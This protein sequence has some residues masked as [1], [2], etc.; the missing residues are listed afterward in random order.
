V[1]HGRRD[2]HAGA[3][4]PEPS[5]PAVPH[6]EGGGDGEARGLDSRPPDGVARP[7]ARPRPRPRDG[8][9]GRLGGA[10]V[11][12][13]SSLPAPLL[14]LPAP[15][16]DD[17]G[18]GPRRRFGFG[19][20]PEPVPAV[21]PPSQGGWTTPSVIVRR[22]DGSVV[23]AP[24]RTALAHP[25]RTPWPSRPAG[26]P[27][28][29]AV[30]P[31]GASRRRGP[32][33][34]RARPAAG[35]VAQVTATARGS[36]SRAP[37]PPAGAATPDG[38]ADDPRSPAEGTMPVTGRSP[39][40][41]EP[42]PPVPGSAEPAPTVPAGIEPDGRPRRDP[43]PK[44]G[45]PG[46]DR[47]EGSAPGDRRSGD[48]EAGDGRSDP[49]GP[50]DRR[51]G[52]DQPDDRRSGVVGQHDDSAGTAGE[53]TGTGRTPTAV[54]SLAGVGGSVAAQAGSAR[55]G[56]VGALRTA[57][58]VGTSRL[59]PAD[60]AAREALNARLRRAGSYV[61]TVAVACVLIYAVFPVRTYL[62]Q[63]AATQR[64]REQIEVISEQN[65]RL[66]ERVESLGNDDV[67]ERIAREDYG[68]VKPGEES[69]G[70]LPPPEPTTTT[71]PPASGGTTTTPPG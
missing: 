5:A 64:A 21:P 60:P 67:V 53:A 14:S 54:R 29:S 33:S 1:T 11:A 36:A 62:D 39:A 57:R 55:A 59:L 15:D 19:R 43:T 8:R 2:E 10:L 68:M 31:Y 65:D 17:D 70:I 63:R 45:A 49:P 66:E 4:A 9:P 35:P 61:G 22:P 25:P 16:H 42:V 30:P 34:R 58:D 3:A 40:G 44:A 46:D 27:V 12:P 38:P 52:D 23:E 47:S 13:T 6:G 37:G 51:P 32:T 7:E 48:A 56:V 69:Y 20:R 71:A 41:A 26:P 24:E 50:D 28:Q 18:R